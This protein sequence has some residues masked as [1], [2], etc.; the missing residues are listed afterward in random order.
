MH[1]KPSLEQGLPESSFLSHSDREIAFLV[2][3]RRLSISGTF[4]SVVE[5]LAVRVEVNPITPQ[6]RN[7][8]SAIARRLFQGSS[9]LPDQSNFD[10]MKTYTDHG[11]RENAPQ[12]PVQTIW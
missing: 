2:S 1:G 3:R 7:C 9:R 5:D 10:C 12:R 11:R 4:E 8:C 6:D